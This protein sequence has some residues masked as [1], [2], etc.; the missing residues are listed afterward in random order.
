M[1]VARPS[2]SAP[3]SA[4]TARSSAAAASLRAPRERAALLVERLR[5]GGELGFELGGAR[6]AA[7]QPRELRR[8]A[9]AVREDVLD[10]R[11]VAR[12]QPAQRAEAILDLREPAR[13]GLD[14]A[15]RSARAASAASSSSSRARSSARSGSA[16]SGSSSTTPRSVAR[17]AASR[18]RRPSSPST[19]SSAVAAACASRSAW[20]SRRSSRSSSS[21]S[22]GTRRDAVDLLQLEAELVLAARE[23]LA[24]ALARGDRE[25]ELAP[26]R[27]ELPRPRPPR[28]PSSAKASSSS[29]WASARSRRWCSPWLVISSASPTTSAS[30]AAGGEPAVQR[31]PCRGPRAR[32]SA[33]PAARRRP[34]PSR[35]SARARAS[36]SGARK[37]ASTSASAGA[38]AH[39]L[40]PDPLAREQ[41][42]RA[43]QERLPRAGL[44]RDHRQ[45]RRLEL[46]LERLDRDQVADAER[47]DQRE[48]QPSLVR[49]VAKWSRARAD[50]KRAGSLAFTTRTLSPVRTSAPT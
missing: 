31:A 29:A 38:G 45:A 5:G 6:L 18:S 49:R 39:E 34:R 22:P 48:P 37:I 13:V 27:V 19:R 4:A 30:S 15:P 3:S 12:L 46:E 20:P 33:R 50:T 25:R 35:P 1:K 17:A 23:R 16:S 14:P 26:A 24:V 11:A 44:A 47:H 40:G 9:L 10:R 21:S 43:E 28:A 32:R 42:D 7:G 41:R 36:T 8:G 2:S